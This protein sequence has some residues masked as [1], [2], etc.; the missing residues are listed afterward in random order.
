MLRLEIESAYRLCSN[1]NFAQLPEI[2]QTAHY[3][4]T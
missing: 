3:L 2:R 1:P 4:G